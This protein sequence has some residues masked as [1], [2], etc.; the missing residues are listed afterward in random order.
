MGAED[1]NAD[2]FLDGGPIDKLPLADPRPKSLMAAYSTALI[3]LEG[4]RFRNI[5]I[6]ASAIP[7]KVASIQTGVP[8]RVANSE[9]ILWS[10]IVGNR[11]T[12]A[13]KFS[14]YGARYAHQKD[15]GGGSR[16]PARI[17]LTTTE[18]HHLY[19]GEPQR[20]RE[21]CSAAIQNQEFSQQSWGTRAVRDCARGNGD[22]GGATEWVERDTHMHIETVAD[23]IRSRLSEL[24][25]LD[26]LEF[27]KPEQVPQEQQNLLS[28]L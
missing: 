24:G 7:N 14:D 4:R 10:Q 18:R 1:E 28:F 6:C 5:V 27:A 8:H 2:V 19:L 25:V 11:S 13:T 15:G 12:R 16:P 17:H 9:F 3:A 20:Y 23:A 22:Y 26:K 21:L